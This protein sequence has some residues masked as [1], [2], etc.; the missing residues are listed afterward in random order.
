MSL[1]YQLTEFM[2]AWNTRGIDGRCC[3]CNKE[4]GSYNTC[5]IF[6]SGLC[7]NCTA[8]TMESPSLHMT[9][10]RVAEALTGQVNISIDQWV[11][12]DKTR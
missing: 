5:T 4:H 1:A 12:N 10:H 6:N 7:I 9:M 2:D 11:D 8:E 3:M